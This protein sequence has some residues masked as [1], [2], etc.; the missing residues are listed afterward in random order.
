MRCDARVMVV[1]LLGGCVVRSG[2]EGTMATGG[3]APAGEEMGEVAGGEAGGGQMIEAG[4]GFNGTQLQGEV[5]AE[6]QVSCPADC[7]TQGATWGSGVYTLDSGV[8]RAGIHAGAIGAAGGL[9]EVRLEPG[10]PAYRGSAHNG[11]Q[12]YDYGSYRMSF[13]VLNASQGEAAPPPDDGG[14]VIEAGCSYNGTQI[15]GDVGAHVVV[16]CPAGCAGQSGVWGSDLYTLDS[17]VCGAAIHAGLIT[18]AGGEVAVE[19]VPGRPAYRGTLRNGIRSNDYGNY[20][21]SFRVEQP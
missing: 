2:M 16:N 20:Q 21:K 7:A 18:D 9:V 13:A 19:I 11:I 12:S 8:C 1:V 3:G 14:Q 4:C 15:V 6:F 17:G 5:G 10:R